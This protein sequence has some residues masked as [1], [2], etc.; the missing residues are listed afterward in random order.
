MTKQIDLTGKRFGRLVVLR[1]SEKRRR[2]MSVWVCICDCGNIAEAT[3]LDLRDGS[4]KSCK[5][6]TIERAKLMGKNNKIDYGLASFNELYRA[7][8]NS[9]ENRNYTFNLTKEQFRNITSC[10]CHYCG[11]ESSRKYQPRESFNGPYIC[12]GIDRIDNTKG[13]EIDNVVP[14]C[15]ICNRAKQCMT[16]TEFIAWIKRLIEFNLDKI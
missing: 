12:N 13:Y 10:S 8:K 6:L 7:Y 14:C 2:G 9:A 11:I 15:D 3:G 5:C 16:Y 1:K 4:T